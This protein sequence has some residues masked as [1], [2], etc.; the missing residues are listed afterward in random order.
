MN[1][2]TAQ[3][4]L[5][6]STLVAGIFELTSI[7]FIQQPLGSLT[8]GIVFLAAGAWLWRA[9]GILAPTLL[10]LL[11]AV[12]LSGEPM[13]Q[14]TGLSDWIIQMT[15]GVL[16]LAGLLAA[17]VVVRERVRLRRSRPAVA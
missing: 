11:F 13:Y 8:A 12:E 2:R 5:V 16:S 1:P 7:P 17:V 9:R 10:G 6:G 15:L 3:H 4:V 14:R